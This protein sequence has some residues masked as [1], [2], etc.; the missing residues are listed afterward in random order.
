M[1]NTNPLA[2]HLNRN[3][4]LLYISCHC[5]ISSCFIL[6]REWSDVTKIQCA[7]SPQQSILLDQQL[8]LQATAACCFFY[9]SPR[10]PTRL[11]KIYFQ[12]ASHSRLSPASSLHANH[13]PTWWIHPGEGPRRETT[14]T[15]QLEKSDPSY[16]SFSALGLGFCSSASSVNLWWEWLQH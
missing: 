11:L 16:L 7:L 8:E 13:L 15:A 4:A 5:G 10:G 3:M 2:D 14:K 12:P 1:R 6:Y 9:S